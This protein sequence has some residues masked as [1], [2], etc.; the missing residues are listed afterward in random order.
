MTDN[1]RDR[2]D[3]FLRVLEKYDFAAAQEMCTKKAVVWQN[4]GKK[5]QAIGERLDQFRSFVTTVDSIRYEVLRRFDAPDEV[6]QQ[7]VL[8]LN[9]TD[10]SSNA[11]NALL[12][13]RFE[14]GLIDRIEEY[15]YPMPAS[16][17]AA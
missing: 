2:V 13:F 5:E 8:H 10:G 3:L 15:V 12:H 16:G 11:L 7:H 4:D 9:M 1:I 6:M 17:E 14:D